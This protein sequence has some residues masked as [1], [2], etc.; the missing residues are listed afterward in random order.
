MKNM[1]RISC[2]MLAL[3]MALCMGISSFALATPDKV[4]TE[5]GKEVTIKFTYEKIMGVNGTFSFSNPD[6]ISDV[7]VV[8]D[9]NSN[10]SGSFGKESY[11]AWYYAGAVADCTIV[12]TVTVSKNAKPG[13]ECV[14]NFNY[15][16]TADGEWAEVPEYSD[17]SCRIYIAE[18][19]VELDYTALKKTIKTAEGLTEKA[20]TP[21]SWAA[22]V[23]VLKDAKALVDNADT[24]GEIDDMT[25]KL[26]AAIDALVPIVPPTGDLTVLSVAVFAVA[27]AGAVVFFNKRRVSVR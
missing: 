22:M 15:E 19:E 6:M 20:Y 9:E 5:A 1:K 17:D 13:D 11:A 4:A 21:D 14:I 26:Q 25:A 7:K 10:F 16:T 24:Q 12:M 18:E 2:L 23:A 8:L 27:L 3:L